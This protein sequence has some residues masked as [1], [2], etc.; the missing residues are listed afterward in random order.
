[1]ADWCRLC[2]KKLGKF[3]KSSPLTD[4]HPEIP[5][6]EDCAVQRDR[7]S[8]SEPRTAT[9]RVIRDNAVSFFRSKLND[10]YVHDDVKAVIAEMIGVSV[11]EAAEEAAAKES[12]D[13]AVERFESDRSTIIAVTT[14]SVSGRTVAE[15]MGLATADSVIGTGALSEMSAAMSNFTGGSSDSMA[16]KISEAKKSAVDGMCVNAARMGANAVL[17]VRIDVYIL[18]ANTIG[19]S[20][21]GTAAKVE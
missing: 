11:E 20:A 6:C 17:G 9:E 3:S 21:T 8:A 5:I 10:R 1:M 14:D 19:V 13:R 18:S 4:G 15:V 16:R 2:N 12:A 7:L